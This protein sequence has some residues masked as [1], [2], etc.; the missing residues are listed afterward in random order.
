MRHF[1]YIAI[2]L[3]FFTVI[4]AESAMLQFIYENF[5]FEN[6]KKKD[7]GERFRAAVNYQKDADLYQFVYEKTHT[8]TFKPPLTKDLHVNKIFLKYTRNLDEKQSF[9][10]SYVRIDDNIMKEVDGGNIYG[11]GYKYGAFG[12]TQYLS[13]Y[14]NFNVYQTELKYTFKK[15]FGKIKTFTTVVGKYIRLQNKESNPFS[16]NAQDDYFTPGLKFH[17]HYHEYHMGAGAFFAKRAFAVMYDGFKIQD[18]AM[19]F[20]QT[21]MFGVG[22]HFDDLDVSLNYVY[23]EATELPINN[24]NVKAKNLILQV[25]Y[26]F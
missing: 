8:E 19:E 18:H 12:L 15:A 4:Y 16:A 14:D 25:A 5:N 17:A 21:Y 6:S 22:K 3:L 2:F 10:L 7:N 13:D 24:E 11:L 23:Q 26:R 20:N 1:K 9:S